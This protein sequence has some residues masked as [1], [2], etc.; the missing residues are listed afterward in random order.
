M[1][2]F[3]GKIALVTGAGSG[4]GEGIARRLVA[5]GVTVIAA[6]ISGQQFRLAEELGDR[7]I[8]KHM[9]IA[10]AEDVRQMEEWILL[11]FGHLDILANNAGVVGAQ[12]PMH[13]YPI[14]SAD[15]VFSMKIRGSYLV[16]QA[17]LRL[18]LKNSDKNYNSN[19]GAII[20]TSFLLATRATPN[21]SAYVASKGAI[22][23]MTR[24]AAI[25]Y[26]DKN[27]RVNAVAP[28]AIV[29]SAMSQVEESVVTE[30]KKLIP[31]GRLGEPSDVVNV[32]SFL[33]DNEQAG[34]I[35]GQIWSIDGGKEAW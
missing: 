30:Y 6:D 12:S 25:E 2:R 16:Q 17:A 21:M 31:R 18:M 10:D 26:A 28:G 33:A 23:S 15:Q 9:N 3:T 29:T 5:D 27:I 14:E 7:L 19:G 4:I 13:E 11:K 8:P 24:A 22:A 1:S 20:N 35:T 32:V 34:H